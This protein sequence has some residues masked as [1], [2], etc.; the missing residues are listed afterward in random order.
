MFQLTREEAQALVRLRS[1]N[2]TLKRG[3]HIKHLPYAFTEHGAIQVANVLNSDAA[4]EMGVHVVRAF[5]QLRQWLG[6]Q[7]AFVAKLDELDARVGQHDDQLAAIV[8]ALRQ[9][10]T[11][12]EPHHGR[13]MGFHQGTR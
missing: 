9:L 11:S 13:K 3:Q 2:A 1:Q 10:T 8:E 6:T 7:K 4:I 12:P 5:V